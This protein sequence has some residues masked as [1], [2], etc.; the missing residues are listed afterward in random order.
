ML[1]FNYFGGGMYLLIAAVG[2]WNKKVPINGNRACFCISERS[3]WVEV[4]SD[5]DNNC[6]D[7]IIIVKYYVIQGDGM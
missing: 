3:A 6:R 1:V 2:D 7:S 5:P 4:Y